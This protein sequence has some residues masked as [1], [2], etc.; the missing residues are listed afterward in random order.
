MKAIIYYSLTGN[1]DRTV[2][3]RFEGD[4]YRLRGRIRIPRGTWLRYLYLGF[5]ASVDARLRY[6][7]V[8]IDLD[9]YDEIVLASPVW[10]FTIVP[11]MKKFLRDHRIQGKKV[12]LLVTHEGGPGRALRHFRRL[13][14]GADD[15]VQELSVQQGVRYDGMRK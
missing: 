12:T 6:E 1:T 11:F 5:F 15:I 14:H 9:R 8:D 7:P 13:L 10:A 4:F 3:E 2:H